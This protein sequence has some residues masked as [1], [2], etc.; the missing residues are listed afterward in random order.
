MAKVWAFAALGNHPLIRGPDI[1][2]T[3]L[4]TL[5]IPAHLVVS[6]LNITS[7]QVLCLQHSQLEKINI[8]CPSTTIR[9]FLLV[10]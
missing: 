4:L 7:T 3:K 9:P 2:N 8:L 5:K 6:T 1:V 10:C